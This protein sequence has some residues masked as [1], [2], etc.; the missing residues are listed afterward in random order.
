[1]VFIIGLLAIIA[2]ARVP[3]PLRV[4]GDAAWAG[5]AEPD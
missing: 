2:M 4:D 1:M 3:V 5:S